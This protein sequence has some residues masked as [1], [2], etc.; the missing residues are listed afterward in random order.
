MIEIYTNEVGKSRVVDT[1]SLLYSKMR[2]QW[3]S[4]FESRL[5]NEYPDVMKGV[6]IQIVGSVAKGLASPDSDIDIVIKSKSS[7]RLLVPKVRNAIFSLLDQ[8]K[9]SG[10]KIYSVEIQ[11]V[12]N[13]LMFSAVA[14]LKRQK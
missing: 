5:R 7:D 2:Q 4:D 11:E 8:M 14:K 6:K 9:E 10:D 12:G 1:D 3:F 13:P